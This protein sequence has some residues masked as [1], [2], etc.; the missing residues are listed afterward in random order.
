MD[1]HWS[2]EVSALEH[3]SDVL[4]MFAN[5][6]AA[7]RI[8]WFVGERLDAATIFVKT[9]VMCCLFVREAHHLIS[10]LDDASVVVRRLLCQCERREE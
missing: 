6:F 7:C 1:Q 5:F 3:A 8:A 10:A 9:K 4:Q 2:I